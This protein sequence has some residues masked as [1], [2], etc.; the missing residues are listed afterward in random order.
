[1]QAGE[2]GRIAAVNFTRPGNWTI[3]LEAKDRKGKT[4]ESRAT[5]KI[6]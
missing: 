5:V 6:Q 1:V 4:R 2:L 3:R